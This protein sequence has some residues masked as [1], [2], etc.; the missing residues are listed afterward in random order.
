[1]IR[2]FFFQ[3]RFGLLKKNN[4]KLYSDI[5]CFYWTLQYLEY[6]YSNFFCYLAKRTKKKYQN[7]FVFVVAYNF[8]SQ[9]QHLNNHKCFEYMFAFLT[10]WNVDLDSKFM[11]KMNVN[12]DENLIK[13]VN[14]RLHTTKGSWKFEF[15]GKI[16]FLSLKFYS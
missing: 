1:M 6:L 7:T 16:Q 3:K 8:C 9:G 12:N 13:R 14:N 5:V 15:A 10:R 4:S 11:Q 2:I